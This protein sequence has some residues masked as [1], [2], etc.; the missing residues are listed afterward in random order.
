MR[1]FAFVGLLFLVA[2]STPRES[3]NDTTIQTI[4][5]QGRETLSASLPLYFPRYT[6]DGSALLA[7]QPKY[8]GLNLYRFASGRWT[9]LSGAESAGFGYVI[10]PD[11]RFGCVRERV[12]T[13]RRRSLYR[14]VRYDLNTGD[15]L[16]L[17][18]SGSLSLPHLDR[19]G[20]HVLF[21]ADKEIQGFQLES[22]TPVT[23]EDCSFLFFEIDRSQLIR[24][25]PQKRT[26]FQPFGDA[27]IVSVQQRAGREQWTVEV[28]GRGSFL[29]D[30]EAHILRELGDR[31]Q[32]GWAPDYDCFAYVVE[33]DDG[34]R[35]TRSDVMVAWS[36]SLVTKALTQTQDRLERAPSWS[37]S[38]DKVAC[39]TEEGE[40][41]L[42]SVKINRV[43]VSDD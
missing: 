8:Q 31:R 25:T 30:K 11:S 35:I 13:G 15:A 1:R 5:V 42:I 26:P 19:T 27:M 20:T 14:M 10:S 41:D 36:D 21:L 29:I 17:K 43:G 12:R 37:P 34:H 24:Y 22:G 6:P 23:P 33:E 7:T 16:I 32:V 2:C 38:A 39:H 4:T 28:A 3:Q 40:I 18:E 9:R